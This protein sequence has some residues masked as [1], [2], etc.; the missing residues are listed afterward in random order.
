VDLAGALLW[1]SLAAAAMPLGAMLA[2]LLA[3][4]HRAIAAVMSLGAGLLLGAVSFDLAAEALE[5]VEPPL[6][7][8]AIGS[9]AIL[10][11]LI[12]AGLSAGGAQHRKRCGGCVQQ[13]SEAERPGSGTAIAI[14]TVL[15]GIPEAA[16]LG[17]T[18]LMSGLEPALLAAI[19]LGNIAQAISATSGMIEAGRP[20]RRIMLIWLAAAASFIAATLVGAL[21]LGGL[22][23]GTTALIG[24][25]AA[26]ALLA[27]IAEA[28]L[29]E[30]FHL[31]PRFSGTLAASG[32]A[33]ALMLA[34]VQ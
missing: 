18:F 32:F 29:P 1:S 2:L 23:T 4:P 28:L 8:L 19:I 22:G 5:R 16:V 17:I 33:A 7:A 15:D 27:M 13:A 12:N 21:A 31:S 3:L 34:A 26:G 14:G 6:A 30:A 25:F 10:F 20:V 11:S 9:G 24:A